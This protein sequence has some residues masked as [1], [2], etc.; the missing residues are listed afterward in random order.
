MGCNKSKSDF[1]K[2]NDNYIIDIKMCAIVLNFRL[3]YPL[4]NALENK[5]IHSEEK[6]TKIEE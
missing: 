2:E 3:R 1:N 5:F 4:Y 6:D